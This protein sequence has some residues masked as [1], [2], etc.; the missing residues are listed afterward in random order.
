[1]END[2]KKLLDSRPT[3][4]T[5]YLTMAYIA[6]QA[7]FD[8]SSKCGSII[9]SKDG[10][11]LS[12]GYN[13]PIKNSIDEEIPL[14]RPDK[15]CHFIHSEENAILAYNGSYQDIAG[16]TIYIT[17]RPCHRCL[18]MII[19]KGITKIVYS[20]NNTM[21]VDQ[22]DMDAQVIMLRHHPEV[23]IVEIMD[24]SDVQ[25]LLA[26]TNDYIEAKKC[27]RPNYST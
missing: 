18:R 27:V 21:V 13:G 25:S 4:Y 10:R 6:S 14:V 1:M 20:Q 19:Q 12:T 9:V 2:I 11:I 17:G 5:Y 23:E 22:S 16:S 26:K 15:Y 3:K 24:N 7:S 8:P